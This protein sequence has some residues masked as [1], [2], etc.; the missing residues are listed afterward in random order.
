M[1]NKQNL[2]TAM[3]IALSFIIAVG[4]W[5]LTS[6]LI[7]RKSDTLLSATGSIQVN[8]PPVSPIDT[9][10][11]DE[12]PPHRPTLSE[13]EMVK[14]LQNWEAVIGE[15]PHEPVDGQLNM[16]QAI[17]A[18]KAGLSYFHEQGI[19]PAELLKFDKTNAYLC[20]KQPRGQENYT[21]NPNYSYWTI[22]FSG[23]NRRATLVINAMTGQIWEAAFSGAGI[24][25]T[26]KALEA[27]TSYLDLG[28]GG[29]YISDGTISMKSYSDGMLYAI[30]RSYT[31]TTTVGE[32]GLEG[33]LSM[34][35]STQAQ[36]LSK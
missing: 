26:E 34:H 19:I 16:E 32:D 18:G 11:D 3:G 5:V 33:F 35:L 8:T 21:L 10:D 15:R 20:E 25:E 9:N 12:T 4:G 36:L 14:V 23:E 30:A 24:A 1:V 17:D 27:F 31:A 22:T 6:T 7:D 29:S 13:S 2:Y 28:E